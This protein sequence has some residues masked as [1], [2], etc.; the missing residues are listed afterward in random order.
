LIKIIDYRMTLP[1]NR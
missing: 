1:P